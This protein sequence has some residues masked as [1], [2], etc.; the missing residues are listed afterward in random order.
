[1]DKL[2]KHIEIRVD[3]AG[4]PV[5]L[6]IDGETFPWYLAPGCDMHLK[7]HDDACSTLTVTLLAERLTVRHGVPE[8]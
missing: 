1:M 6:L 5:D 2:A 4:T 7:G 8:G 3:E